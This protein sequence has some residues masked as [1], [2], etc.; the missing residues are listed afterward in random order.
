M[1]KVDV[2]KILM[3]KK[4]TLEESIFDSLWI[5]P[6]N[7]YLSQND[8]DALH[9]IA[10]SIRLSSKIE[11]KYKM[12]DDIMRARGFKRFGAGTNRVVYSF[13][14]DDRFLVKIAVDKVGMQ[15]NPAEYQNQF[16]LKPYVTK[17]FYVSQCGTVGFVERVMPIK[18]KMEFKEIASDVFD[19]LVNK[20]LGKYVVEDV[21]TKYFM[22]WG[23]RLNE[24]P[25]L[26]DYPY[27]Y[28]LDGNRLFCNA[29]IA[30][31]VICDGEIDYDRGFNHLICSKCG[32]RYLATDLKDNKDSNKII[33][34][35]GQKT[36]KATVYSGNKVIASS[37]SSDEVIR[38]Q[39]DEINAMPKST[40]RLS[41]SIHIPGDDSKKN[42]TAQNQSVTP[43]QQIKNIDNTI[44]YLEG[45][46]K[47]LENTQTDD[48]A[49]K[50]NPAVEF[51]NAFGKA[52]ASIEA[53]A[54][55]TQHNEVVTSSD[56][57]DDKEEADESQSQEVDN[58]SRVEENANAEAEDSDNE[59]SD[60]GEP[61]VS[62]V[63]TDYDDEEDRHYGR[64]DRRDHSDDFKT[65]NR[66]FNRD[67]K[68]GYQSGFI[69]N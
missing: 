51:D 64:H 30:Q 48:C 57:T 45:V 56:N 8:I 20:I 63:E 46:K 33:I 13:L 28:K 42:N 49:S 4:V 55:E 9:S 11:K 44:E 2:L 53:K 31:G 58:Y 16:L 7:C 21:G 39:N 29:E 25:V 52:V 35:G 1:A 10:T 66:K 12:I 32:K 26:L 23:V 59:N 54:I 69:N 37:V 36:M 40:T 47:K 43:E 38:R 65:R 62:S 3:S 41:V 18:N 22:N 24:G 15:D 14:E 27:I 68:R 19:I 61:D 34:K 60:D 17:M 50:E 67:M 5:Y 6:M